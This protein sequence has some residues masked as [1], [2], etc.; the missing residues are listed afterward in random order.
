VTYGAPA[1]ISFLS[2]GII[3]AYLPLPYTASFTLSMPEEMN[4]PPAHW[5]YSYDRREYYWLPIFFPVAD[6]LS[7]F[8][9]DEID[10]SLKPGENRRT[11]TR[12]KTEEKRRLVLRFLQDAKPLLHEH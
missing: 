7:T 1:I 12:W 4:V 6:Y 5:D 10:T 3:P 8:S 11:D 9:D 2:F